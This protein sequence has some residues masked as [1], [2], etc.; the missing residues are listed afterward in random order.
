MAR[1]SD[2]LKDIYDSLFSDIPS[3]Y[4]YWGRLPSFKYSLSMDR[5]GYI[6]R[7]INDRVNR[8]SKISISKLLG[9]LDAEWLE[10]QLCNYDLDG[11]NLLSEENKSLVEKMLVDNLEQIEKSYE[12][13][14]NI[15]KE[16]LKSIIGAAKKLQL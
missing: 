7:N 5:F 16:Y 12:K 15:G 14:K 9:L 1:D 11:S 13:E 10:D 3:E 8:K 2:V 4:L 6:Q